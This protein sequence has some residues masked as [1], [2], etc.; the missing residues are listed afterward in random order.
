MCDIYF[1]VSTRGRQDLTRSNAASSVI[2]LISHTQR[3]APLANLG[4]LR[5]FIQGTLESCKN[6]NTNF[7]GHKNKA[8]DFRESITFDHFPF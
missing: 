7:W 4:R 8:G 1:N 6:A 5:K 3:D 2:F